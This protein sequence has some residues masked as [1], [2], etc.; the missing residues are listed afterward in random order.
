MSSQLYELKVAKTRT[1]PILQRDRR[2]G[3]GRF[4]SRRRLTEKGDSL[5]LDHHIAAPFVARLQSLC[6]LS[7]PARVRAGGKRMEWVG[8]GVRWEIRIYSSSGR[9]RCYRMASYL[10][11]VSQFEVLKP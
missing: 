5:E 10:V 7:P 3:S 6:R 8:V 4:W 1:I 9:A 2:K 11:V